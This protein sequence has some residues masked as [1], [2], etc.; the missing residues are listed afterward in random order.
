MDP[1]INAYLIGI[2]E[3]MV[4]ESFN[5]DYRCFHS[6]CLDFNTMKVFCVRSTELQKSSCHVMLAKTLGSAK[7][8]RQDM[9]ENHAQEIE[10]CDTMVLNNMCD[11]LLRTNEANI[12]EKFV[13][14]RLELNGKNAMWDYV[15]CVSQIILKSNLLLL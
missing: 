15:T 14:Y 9:K 7:Q 6:K 2:R 1:N 3:K 11:Q 5:L 10:I 13:N 8:F 4:V 12:R